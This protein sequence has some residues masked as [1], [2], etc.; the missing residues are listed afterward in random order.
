MLSARRGFDPHAGQSP[1]EA[2]VFSI[3]HQ[4]PAANEFIRR[5]NSIMD[6]RH[7]ERTHNFH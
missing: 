7:K 4:K 6:N 1:A 2:M 3:P 5:W